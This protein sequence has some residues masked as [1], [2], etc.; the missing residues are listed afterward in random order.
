MNIIIAGIGNVGEF[1]AK[2]LIKEKHSITIIDSD[3]ELIDNINVQYDLLSVVG[4]C[5]SIDTLKKANVSHC[6]LFIA[7]TSTE[8]TN[9][10]ACIMA[11]KM[12]QKK[13]L[14]EL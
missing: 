9:L 7:V 10:L 4:S 11:K 2:M 1:L 8:E 6:D 5:Y 13:L 14:Q 3:A 12:V